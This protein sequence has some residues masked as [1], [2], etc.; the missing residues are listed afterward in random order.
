M[1][2][3]VLFDFDGVIVDSEQAHFEA[4]RQA[5]RSE[6][7][8]L[9]WSQY[10]QKYLGYSDLDCF[11]QILSDY[12]NLSS[13][14]LINRLMRE[15]K[16]FFTHFLQEKGSSI[17]LPGVPELLESLRAKKIY[18]SIYS[19]S[20]RQEIVTILR[21][22]QL[23]E[24]F[25]VII[26]AEDVRQGKP[27]PEGYLLALERTNT[28]VNHH[29]PIHPNQCLVIEDSTWGIDAARAANMCCLAV[30][31]TYPGDQLQAASHIAKNLAQLDAEHLQAML[32]TK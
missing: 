31:N 26:S 18:R 27:D 28:A 23:E 32:S 29:P 10:S 7:I 21:Q 19:G 9:N 17:L 4:I 11:V 24:Y 14:V 22:A 30:E 5:L 15:K 25:T 2:R 20:L 8:D 3:L 1:L 6:N 16:E 12:K 13:S